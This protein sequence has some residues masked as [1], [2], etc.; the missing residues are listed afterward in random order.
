MDRSGAAKL[1]DNSPPVL[2]DYDMIGKL[3]VFPHNMTASSI[4]AYGNLIYVV[5]GNGVD[6]T[7]K[8]VVAP[9]APSIVCFNKNTGKVVWTNNSPGP[10]VL[11]GQ[12]A[13]P[14]VVEVNGR[15]LVIAPL[16]ERCAP[17]L[18]KSSC[19]SDATSATVAVPPPPQLF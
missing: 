9:D 12:W 4:V 13:S 15:G 1:A 7:H 17:V 5:T 8:H 2:W 3:G 10:N 18:P 14:A 16:G 11:H 19:E 6:D